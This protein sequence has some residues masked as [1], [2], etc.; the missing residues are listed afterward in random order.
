MKLK[1]RL[2][3]LLTFVISFSG[4]V[5]CQII[6]KTDSLQSFIEKYQY[7]D[8]I[9]LADRYLSK[10]SSNIRIL[11]IKGKAQSSGYMLKDAVETYKKVLGLDPENIISL[12]E[13]V[14]TFKNLGVFDSSI[15]YSKKQIVIQPENSYFKEQLAE[16]YYSNKNFIAAINVLKLIG[17]TNNFYI[18]KQIGNCYF[19]LESMDSAKV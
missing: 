13:L 9:K 11:L 18:L 16:L 5:F 4:N 14:N 19:E 15:I 12:Q 2:L 10:D 7:D 8:A 3:I 17:K 6:S 1:N